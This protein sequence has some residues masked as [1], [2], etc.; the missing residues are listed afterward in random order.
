MRT[1]AGSLPD[2]AVTARRGRKL[3][4]DRWPGAKM[5]VLIAH[6]F[7]RLSGGEDVAVM[8]EIEMLKRNGHDVSLISAHNDDIKGISKTITTAMGTIHNI[9][10][11]RQVAERIREFEPSLLH[12]HNFFPQFS[13]SIFGAARKANVPSIMT[14]HNYRTLC[15]TGV[16]YHNGQTTER[17]LHSSAWWTVRE[18]AYR[19]SLLGSFVTAA[20]VEWHKRRR[21]WQTQVD[22]FVAL[23]PFAKRKFVEAELPPDR[24][25][26]KPNWA[27][28]PSC[29]VL[30]SSSVRHGALYVGRLSEEKGVRTLIEAWRFMDYPLR[31]AGD[32]PL[33]AWL[34]EQRVSNVSYLGRLNSD[35]VQAEMLRASFLVMPSVCYEMFPVTLAEAFGCALPVIA[36]R[37]GSLATLVEHR[38]TGLHFE[39]ADSVGLRDQVIWAIGHPQGMRKLGN[40]ARATFE[41]HYTQEANYAALMEIYDRT[42][43]TSRNR[44]LSAASASAD[45][46]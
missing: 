43:K 33:R 10:S 37:L 18:R 30:T 4:A 14:L 7:Y 46:G 41:S 35:Q 11:E 12:V 28:G 25:A 3:N 6:N 20:M 23:T 38:S 44:R 13:P 2:T 17:S 42:L 40:T 45:G 9:R 32:G 27:N 36:S 15:P 19:G 31:V 8:N 39:A 5:R 26:I 22:Q 16:L 34:T 29:A 21:T 24:I 1:D